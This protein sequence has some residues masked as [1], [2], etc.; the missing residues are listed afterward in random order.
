MNEPPL[1]FANLLGHEGAKALLQSAFARHKVGHAYLFRGPAGVGKKR[2]AFTMAKY[3]HCRRPIAKDVCNGCIACKKVESDSHPDLMKVLPDGAFIKINQIRDLQPFLAFPPLESDYRVIV[4]VDVHT[5]RHEAA[6]AL[7]KTLEEPP[8]NTLLILTADEATKLLPTIVSRCQVVPFHRLPDPLVVKL[9]LARAEI[10][11][12]EALLLATVSDG[13]PGKAL[14][15]TTTELLSFRKELTAIFMNSIQGQPTTVEEVMNLAR[16]AA[17]FKENLIEL[18]YLL[19]I[20]IR[21]LMC[22]TLGMPASFLINQ[23]LLPALLSARQGSKIEDLSRK[24]G[25]IEQACA[26][27]ARNCDRELVCEVLF[28]GLL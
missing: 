10:T 14:L 6:N 17:T 13:S 9:V 11:R 3:I 7:L 25:L 27:L 4:L 28:F 2:S 1:S 19:K 26:Q 5:M 8:P 12:E 20:W 16:Q 24:F 15:L 21:D 22:L 18:F 23:D